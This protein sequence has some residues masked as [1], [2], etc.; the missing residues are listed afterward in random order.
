MGIQH[1][2]PGSS[3]WS[4]RGAMLVSSLAG[5]LTTDAFAAEAPAR[6]A[7]AAGKTERCIPIHSIRQTKVVDDQTIIFY[8]TGNRN[9]M[10]R[11][12]H[13]CGGLE[14]ADS[15]S[16]KTSQ[17]QLCNVDIITVLNR[18][19]SSFAPGPSCGLGEF[20]PIDAGQLEELTGKRDR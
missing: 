9:F 18:M 3:G 5:L 13:N 15:F 19:G 1:A 12:S 20:E 10:N 11:L 14:M 17:S 6:E 4:V 7:P 8:T 2:Q 16:Y